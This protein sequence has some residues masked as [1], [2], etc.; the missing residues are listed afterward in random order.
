[1]EKFSYLKIAQDLIAKLTEREKEV[2]SR[3]FGFGN[4]KRETLESIGKNY[5]VCRERIRQIQEIA[6]K[7]VKENLGAYKDVFVFFE[8]YFKKFGGARKE[9]R[10]FQELAPKEKNEVFF[11]F[12]LWPNFHR[13]RENKDFFS[14]WA[15]HPKGLEFLRKTIDSIIFQLKKAK[16]PLSIEQIESQYPK[17]VLEG[18]LEISKRIGKDKK[19][20]YGLR[21]WPEIFPRGVKDKAYLVLKEAG[22]PL[23]FSEIAKFI[24]NAN[25]HTVHNELIRDQ[26]FVLVGRG[27]Y[28]LAEWGYEPGQ[29][30]DIIVKILAKEKRP[31]TKKEI[32]ER[33][34]RERFV[35]ENTILM[36]LSDRKNFWRDE[37]GRY[38]LKTEIA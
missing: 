15:N 18:F 10:I 35:K 30:K 24:E 37:E 20:F 7:K 27:I 25:L 31:L 34:L 17:E 16:S 22:K 28:A 6:L 11:L 8:E 23:H 29:V 5:G 13:F 38:H 32:V 36:N 3:R 1:M 33:V 12:S 21:E 14:F 26:R 2:I 9:E 19:G 4:G